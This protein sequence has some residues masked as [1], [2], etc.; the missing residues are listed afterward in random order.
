MVFGKAC[1]GQ[2]KVASNYSHN[3]SKAAY[4]RDQDD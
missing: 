3:L 4:C 1:P 2:M